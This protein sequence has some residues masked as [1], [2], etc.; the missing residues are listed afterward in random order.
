MDDDRLVALVTGAASPIGLG[1]GIVRR[2][3]RDGW[4]VVVLDRDERVRS[5]VRKI[6]AESNIAPGS[7]VEHV[8][9]VTAEDAVEAAV[10]I[11]ASTFGRLDAAIANA[12]TGGVE[13]D[14]VDMTPV[15]FD[16]IV[17]IN[18]RG[19]YLTA[20][21]AGRT[22]RQARRGS[23]VLISSIF[24]QEPVAR[25]AAYSATKAGVIAMA[26]AMALEMAPFNV[27]VNAIAPGYMLTEMLLGGYRQRAQHAGITAEQEQDRVS[28]L[29]PLGRHGSGDDLGSAVAFLVS[30]D[31][32]YITG[33]TLG[34]TGGMVRR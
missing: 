2:L 29:I 12:G 16:S 11:A 9:D 24:G 33:H 22:M 25:T 6:E 10:T 13:I 32:S 30:D 18:L 3:A 26:Q 34:V 17:A 15:D 21:A 8:G 19:V 1:A 20:R 27:R 31:A 7:I 5:T 28:K 14:L 23:I 4:R